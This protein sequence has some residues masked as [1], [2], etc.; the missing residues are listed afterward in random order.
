MA[1]VTRF[2]KRKDASYVAT[3]KAAQNIGGEIQNAG[4][5]LQYSRA[6]GPARER[7]DR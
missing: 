5:F 4:I 7:S 1:P 6:E 2:K 3:K